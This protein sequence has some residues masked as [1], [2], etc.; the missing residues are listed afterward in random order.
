MMHTTVAERVRAIEGEGFDYGRE[1]TRIEGVCGQGVPP[2]YGP[3][4]PEYQPITLRNYKNIPQIQVL[5]EEERFAIEVVS[6]VLPFRTNNY[7]VEELIDWKD[8]PNDPFLG[9]LFPT[10]RCS[11]QDTLKRC[12]GLSGRGQVGKKS[13]KRP[14]RFGGS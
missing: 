10:R 6:Q 4:V 7:V 2:S 11:S 5:T 1:I 8:I 12:P 14:M 3:E 13:E 9:L